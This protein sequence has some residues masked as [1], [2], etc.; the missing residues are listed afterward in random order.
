[1]ARG[2]WGGLGW[3]GFSAKELKSLS[4]VGPVD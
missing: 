4:G 1:M 2:G 3:V